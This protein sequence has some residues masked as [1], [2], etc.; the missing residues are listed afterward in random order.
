MA[1]RPMRIRDFV[2]KDATYVYF[3]VIFPAIYNKSVNTNYVQICPLL[4]LDRPEGANM[5]VPEGG[6]R[7]ANLDCQ[8]LA[9]VS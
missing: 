5:L 6:Y 9:L 3:L 8:L 2:P 4:T 7:S 1:S